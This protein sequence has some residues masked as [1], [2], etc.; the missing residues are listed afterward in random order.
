MGV[1]GVIGFIGVTL[2]ALGAVR[3]PILRYTVVTNTTVLLRY[4]YGTTT[5]LLRYDY[6]MTT[7]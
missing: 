2:Q 1:M 3:S 4:D 7:V 6:G 5:V